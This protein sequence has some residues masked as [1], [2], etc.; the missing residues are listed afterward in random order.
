[1]NINESIPSKDLFNTRK[2]TSLLPRFGSVAD[3]YNEL[4]ETGE[5]E[6]L[7][8]INEQKQ[9]I[10]D[11]ESRINLLQQA[12]DERNNEESER[13]TKKRKRD[14]TEHS[15]SSDNL[16][17][18]VEDLEVALEKKDAELEE[19]QEMLAVSEWGERT[20]Q[21]PEADLLNKVSTLIEKKMQ[22][23]EKKFDAME[24]KMIEKSTEDAKKVTLSFSNAVSKNLNQNIVNNVIQESKNTDRIIESERNKR[25]K[26]VI[27]HGVLEVAESQ[28][29]IVYD[30]DYVKSLFRILGL[31]IEP[32]SISRLGMTTGNNEALSRPI[33]LTMS[34]VEHKD[35]VLS[36]LVNLKNAEEK[37]RRISV[38]EDYTYEERE[39]VRK[40]KPTHV[41]R[42]KIQ[43]TG[44]YE[45]IQKTGSD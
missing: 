33:K 36:R 17:K 12:L 29:N 38:K 11:L 2:I 28:N 35:L 6:L 4:K 20:S 13:G 25:E 31:T 16:T 8:T 14:T 3:I 1:M 9:T 34:S 21:V 27:I 44:E 32:S 42:R 43:M 10:A 41:T 30:Q 23:F 15:D 45:R 39:L 24:H 5:R 40:K 7:K 37:Y 19:T 26:N 22:I 18:K